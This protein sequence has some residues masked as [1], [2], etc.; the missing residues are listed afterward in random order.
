[1]ERFHSC[2]L[3]FI[4]SWLYC[5]SSSAQLYSH[6][7]VKIR[8]VIP[9]HKMSLT[10]GKSYQL[11]DK[12][13]KRYECVSREERVKFDDTWQDSDV[14]HVVHVLQIVCFVSS[15]RSLHYRRS[16]EGVRWFM[17]I[18]IF[19]LCPYVTPATTPNLSSPTSLLRMLGLLK[20]PRGVFSSAQIWLSV[21]QWSPV[22]DPSLVIR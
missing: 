9:L 10:I 17:E 4:H 19:R 20:P 21:L 6:I 16:K 1:M 18:R 2:I 15:C 5:P 22:P 7:K 11:E 12:R 3:K 13:L 14:L 8:G